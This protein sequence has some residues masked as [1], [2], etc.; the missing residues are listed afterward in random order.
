MYLDRDDPSVT[1]P[2]RRGGK[3]ALPRDQA[4]YGEKY[5]DPA[6]L[7]GPTYFASYPGL[8]TRTFLCDSKV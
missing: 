6:K 1:M 7:D 2:A 3:A 8:Q 4:Y 5:F